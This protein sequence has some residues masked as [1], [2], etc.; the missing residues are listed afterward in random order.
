MCSVTTIL[1]SLRVVQYEC[2]N[3]AVSLH[4]GIGIVTVVLPLT[5]TFIL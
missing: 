2:W 1:L 3:L 4:R 5:V